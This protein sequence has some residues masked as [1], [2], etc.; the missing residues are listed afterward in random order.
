MNKYERHNVIINSN[1]N[2]SIKIDAG[3]GNHLFAHPIVFV[4][5]LKLLP[6]DSKLF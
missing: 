4:V 6:C 3:H 2:Q 1:K 5:K